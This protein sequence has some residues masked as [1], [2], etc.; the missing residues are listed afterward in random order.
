MRTNAN[1]IAHSLGITLG[2]YL[3]ILIA[4]D[5]DIVG[6]NG[7]PSWADPDVDLVDSIPLPSAVEEH[8]A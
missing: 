3:E 6:E 5:N 2:R 8:A 4:R 1:E 7:K